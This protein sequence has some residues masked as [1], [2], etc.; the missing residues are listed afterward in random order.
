MTTTTTTVTD[1]APAR[2]RPG[3][4]KGGLLAALVV[5]VCWAVAI[6]YWRASGR[7]PTAVDMALFLL[8]LPLALIMATG[9]V[10]ASVTKPA[11]TTDSPAPPPPVKMQDARSPLAVLAAALRSPHGQAPEELA[12]AIL[13]STARPDL[14]PELVDD[15]GFPLMTMR[16]ADATDESL[17]QEIIAWWTAN[18]IPPPRLRDEQWRAITMATAVVGELAS[19][20]ANDLM[21]AE[22]KPPMLRLVPLLPHNWSIDQRRAAGAWLRHTAVQFGWP[23]GYME[24]VDEKAE[25]AP[26]A[27]LS[28][29]ASP[30]V[31]G[32][33]V[34]A[35]MVACASNIGNETVAEWSANGA[36]FT[37][38]HPQGM[39]PGEGAAGL[40]LT[41]LQQARA[42][43][44]V[45]FT[46]LYPVAEARRDVSA[47]D[48]RRTDPKLLAE[49]ADRALASGDASLRDIAM[50]V[51][52]TGHRSNRVLELMGLASDAMPQLD[53]VADVVR[54]GAA[55]GTCDCV[56]FLTALALGRHHALEH[57]APVLCISNE[58]PYQ[59]CAVLIRPYASA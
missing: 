39:I 32:A 17:Q 23:Q 40:L 13:A 29:L 6:W 49:L 7:I 19:S 53:G 24:L 46:L 57:S 51:A 50:L 44:E 59:R 12:A 26:T 27:I 56:P 42:L 34:A 3:W 28:G 30:A 45:V 54:A 35:L 18:D 5:G 37:P 38:L 47:D 15:D 41:D 21:P 25:T 36:L 22:G 58:D 48:T 20:A 43:D 33:P 10:R 8:A 1:P 31:S 2:T 14:D 11:P 55:G 16:S 9:F 52:D 4:L